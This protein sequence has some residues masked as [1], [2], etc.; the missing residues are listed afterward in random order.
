MEVRFKEVNLASCNMVKTRKQKKLEYN[1]GCNS[2]SPS[3]I[4]CQV[5]DAK[6]ELDNFSSEPGQES[7][8]QISYNGESIYN[9]TTAKE[10]PSSQSDMDYFQDDSNNQA[11]SMHGEIPY[12]ADITPEI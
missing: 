7:D 3:K 2:D 9:E 1:M 6:V 10:N 8:S 11:N 12:F 4:V 5:K